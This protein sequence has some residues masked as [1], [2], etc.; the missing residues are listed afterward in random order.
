MT[1]SASGADA[2]AITDGPA[3]YGLPLNVSVESEMRYVA[4][5]L[6]W[7][8]MMVPAHAGIAFLVG[9]SAGTTHKIRRISYAR[10]RLMCRDI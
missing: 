7:T 3:S 1:E 4:L 9:G 10:R 5:L 6:I 8:L 2:S